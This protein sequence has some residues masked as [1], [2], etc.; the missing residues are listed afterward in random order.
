MNTRLNNSVESK[1]KRCI[2]CGRIHETGV[3]EKSSG[4]QQHQVERGFCYIIYKRL[5]G[6]YG[7]SYVDILNSY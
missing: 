3:N 7:S 2:I 6:I 1:E 4:I 5:L